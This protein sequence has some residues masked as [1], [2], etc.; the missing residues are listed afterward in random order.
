M[1]TI[2]LK[3]PWQKR[4]PAGQSVKVDVPETES[5]QHDGAHTYCRTFHTPSG[6]EPSTR[7]HL[8]VTEWRG[9]LESI[10]LNGHV[11]DADDH[12]DREISELLEKNNRIEIEIRGVGDQLA[13]LSGEVRLVI[14]DDE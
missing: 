1:H 11:L 8:Q 12:L 9:Q 7:V 10:S 14:H 13:C 6:L 5:T 2:R 4:G 3:H